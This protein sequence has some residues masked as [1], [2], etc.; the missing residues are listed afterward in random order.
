MRSIASQY[1]NSKMRLSEP[2]GRVSILH[3]KTRQQ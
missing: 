2:E 3:E 1:F